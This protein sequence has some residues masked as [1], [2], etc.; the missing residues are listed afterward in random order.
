MTPP[1]PIG[2]MRGG[3]SR[4]QTWLRSPNDRTSFRLHH[5]HIGRRSTRPNVGGG[6][7]S[8]WLSLPY[9]CTGRN[10]SEEHTSELQSL[11]RTSYAVYCLKNK[12]KKV[13][14]K[15]RTTRTA[16]E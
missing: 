7:G 15:H 8:A 3:K 11:M 10:R 2:W 4:Q 13:R 6:S 9:L 16:E 1:W 14:H 5:R 12:N